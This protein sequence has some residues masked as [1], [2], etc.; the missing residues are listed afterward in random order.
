MKYPAFLKENQTIGIC[1]PSAGVG[2]KLESFDLSVSVLKKSYQVVETASVRNDNIRSNDAVNRAKELSSLFLNKNID[3]VMSASGGDFMNEILPF[4]PFDVLAKYPKWFVGASDPTNFIYPYTT[5]YDVATIYGVNAGSFDQLPLHQ[6]C[7]DALDLLQGKQVVQ[8]NFDYYEGTRDFSS[9]T[10]V[11]DTPV[12]WQ[13]NQ[14]SFQTSGRMIGGCIDVIKDLIGTRFDGTKE[15]IEKYKSDGFI[16]VLDNFS[17][18][19]ESLY[20][21]LLQMRYAGYFDYARAIIVGRTLFV[22]SETGMEENEAIERALGDFPI[23][24]QADFGHTRPSWTVIL[25]SIGHF[26]YQDHQASIYFEMK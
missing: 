8:K 25:G 2:R 10:Q 14:T 3:L 21:T 11:F 7:L 16:W 23:F 4:V 1:A 26:T 13:S 6:Y 9:D 15:F 24:Y 18:S 17:L 12:C 22:N 5:K 20:R 19:N